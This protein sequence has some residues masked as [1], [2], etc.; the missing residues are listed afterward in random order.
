MH[1]QTQT[2][3]THVRRPPMLYLA[4]TTVLVINALY[5]A[6]LLIRNP[7]GLTLWQLIVAAAL[8]M[9]ALAV[10]SHSTRV[11]DR[12]IRLEERLR[13]SRI[14]PDDLRHR[15]DDLTP[16]QMVALRFASDSEV[17]DLARRAL[18]GEFQKTAEI[19]QQVK[20]WRGDYL[21]V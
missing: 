16:A 9:V 10:R 21:R 20:D 19:K 2:F 7:G 3:A 18:A 17:P 13:L 1:Q 8:V 15:V 11:Q 4:G 6:W 5:A 12:I 14:L